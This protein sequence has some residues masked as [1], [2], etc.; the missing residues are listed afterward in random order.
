MLVIQPSSIWSRCSAPSCSGRS[1]VKW[2]PLPAVNVTH[3]TLALK[4][5]IPTP[6]QHWRTGSPRSLWK[7]KESKSYFFFTFVHSIISQAVKGNKIIH[8]Q[9][10][11][12]M[13]GLSH[14]YSV[15]NVVSNLRRQVWLLTTFNVLK[16]TKGKYFIHISKRMC[17][18]WINQILKWS[19]PSA[20]SDHPV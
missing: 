16:H 11:F 17:G 9:N 5:Q 10:K 15:R 6:H 4:N 13:L 3:P 14:I 19:L 8:F 18:N 2:C 1:P 12:K 7:Q 20:S